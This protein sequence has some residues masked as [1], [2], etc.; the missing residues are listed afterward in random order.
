[1]RQGVYERNSFRMNNTNNNL[2]KY[3]AHTNDTNDLSN[4]SDSKFLYILQKMLDNYDA[5]KGS[6]IK[7]NDYFNKLVLETDESRIPLFEG[8]IATSIFAK[9]IATFEKIC[10]GCNKSTCECDA[11]RATGLG[12]AEAGLNIAYA[13]NP[14]LISE[15]IQVQI[16]QH[17]SYIVGSGLPL[18][19]LIVL[20]PG[21]GS[22]ISSPISSEAPSPTVPAIYVQLSPFLYNL[23][24]R[25]FNC[26]FCS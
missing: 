24:A 17:N 10:R 18:S 7:V 5:L 22:P 4:M 25:L 1:M 3:D 9:I 19:G 26:I 13:R 20:V 8:I 12:A 11:I 6:H 15:L 23:L 14:S 2:Q 16:F 21:S